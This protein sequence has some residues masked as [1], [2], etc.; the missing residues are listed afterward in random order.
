MQETAGRSHVNSSKLQHP[1]Q[2][3]N[4]LT[5]IQKTFLIESDY[6]FQDTNISTGMDSSSEWGQ[7]ET[8]TTETSTELWWGEH[9]E[10]TLRHSR[11]VTL[12]LIVAYILILIIGVVGNSLVVCVV[13]RSPRMRTVTNLFILNLAI[14][15]L[16]V[17]LFCLPP[18]LLSNIL[19]PWVLGM[20]M[21][22]TVPY[23]QGVS[24][25]ASVYSLVAVSLDRCSAILFPLGGGFTKRKARGIIVIIWCISC[26]LAMPWALY[27]EIIAPDPENHPNMVFCLENWPEG[28]DGDLYFLIGNLLLCYLFPLSLVSLCYILIWLSSS[29]HDSAAALQKVH[30]KAKMGVLKMLIIVVLVFLLSWLPLYAL[31]ARIKLGSS[32]EPWEE[33]LISIATPIAQWLGS[34]NSCINPL[35]Y[36]FLNVKFRRAFQSL[37]PQCFHPK[38][39]SHLS[40]TKSSLLH[41][42]QTSM[43]NMNTT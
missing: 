4:D 13:L 38:H 23:I 16:L 35:L 25:C 29:S 2:V 41:R 10:E 20:W 5:S 19:I 36:A 12:I 37:L 11:T 33:N 6:V 14:A 18:T 24:V 9:G 8:N 21:C 15:D 39:P 3:I 17:V 42:P 27:F 34:S 26:T 30:R 31:F 43:Y 32:L 1:L 7:N 28:L 22:K 40:T